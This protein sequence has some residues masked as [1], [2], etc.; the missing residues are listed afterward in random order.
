MIGHWTLIS[1]AAAANVALNLTLRHVARSL[2]TGSLKGVVTSLLLSPWFALSVVFG[3]VLV[4][5][6]LAAIR[7]YSLGITYTAITSLAMV[8]LTVVGALV[9]NEVVSAMRIGG[10]ALVIAG[11]VLISQG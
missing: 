11:L 2:D 5:A 4:G 3:T 8:G 1:I 6:F 7:Q 10:L 9:F